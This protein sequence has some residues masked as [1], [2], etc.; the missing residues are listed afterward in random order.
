M[1]W[2][3]WLFLAWFLAT[4]YR[5]CGLNAFFNNKQKQKVQNHK[6]GK[7]KR[8]KIQKERI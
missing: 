6:D 7:K 8:N 5:C 2:G 4:K 1:K 3:P